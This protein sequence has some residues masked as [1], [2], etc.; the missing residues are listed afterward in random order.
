MQSDV[1]QDVIWV[2]ENGTLL[3]LTSTE[4]GIVT[5]LVPLRRAA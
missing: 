2:R 3:L 5:N 4:L 1:D